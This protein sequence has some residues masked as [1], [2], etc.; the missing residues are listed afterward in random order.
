MLMQAYFADLKLGLN[1]YKRFH[2]VDYQDD[3][4][5]HLWSYPKLASDKETIEI[6]TLVVQM[7]TDHGAIKN[8]STFLCQ[9][10]AGDNDLSRRV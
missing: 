3:G 10:R 4:S 7:S 6:P 9:Q 5:F 2:V 8:D 1:R